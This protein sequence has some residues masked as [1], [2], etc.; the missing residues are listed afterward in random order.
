MGYQSQRKS[1]RSYGRG[2]KKTLHEKAKTGRRKRGS[3]G[4]LS[5][6]EEPAATVKEVSDKTLKRLHILGSQRFGSSPFSNHFD[7]WLVNVKGVV[8]E[9]ESNPNVN[10]DDEFVKERSQTLSI[11]ETHLEEKRLEEVSLEEAVRNL[12]NSKNLLTE[13]K[14]EYVAT[15]RK[16][17]AQKN[18]EM[19][20]LYK[21][22]DSLRTELDSIVR[23]KTGFF[24]GISKKAREQKEIETTMKLNTLQ[25]ELELTMLNFTEAKEKLKDEYERKKQPAIEQI[26]NRQK[27]IESLD[28]DSS[29]EDRW[30]ACESLVNAVNAFLQRKTL[31]P[32]LSA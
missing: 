32:N 28:T 5:G 7:R 25:R 24:R 26:R 31:Q 23:M 19:R 8:S 17:K 11:I 14:E 3:V 20:R 22:I 10:A 6:E 29:L 2:Y 27:K 30:S 18:S 12:S 21:N 1:P 13:I 16:L 9:F 15:M 4:G